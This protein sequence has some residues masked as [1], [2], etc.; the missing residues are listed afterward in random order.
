MRITPGALAFILMLPGA[1]SGWAD[2]PAGEQIYRKLCASCHGPNGEGTQ[3]NPD[4]LT[5]DKSLEKLAAY[6]D[7]KMPK[8]APEKCVGEDAKRVASYIFDAFYS[9]VA[10]ARVR[11][12]R[13]ELSRLTVRQYRI[14]V[15][16]LVASLTEP[17]PA[18]T[19]RG[20][21]A[22]Y[23][24]GGRRFREDRRVL[25]RVEPRPAFDFIATPA[26]EGLAKDE[27]SIRWTGSLLAPATG[28]YEIILET[29]NGARVLVNDLEQ[30]LIDGWVRSGTEKARRGSIFLLGGR[31]YPLRVEFFKAKNDKISSL[32]LKWK[33]PDGAEEP[34][35]EAALSPGRSPEVMVVKTRFP[36]DDRSMGYERGIGISKEWDEAA[37]GAA[38]EIAGR[39]AA[40][41][42]ELAG[43]RRED[44][45][46][47]K[48]VAEFCRRLAVRAFRRPLTE[49]Q[50]R[51]FV[52][53]HF[54]E[55]PD[56]ETAVKR[57]L[58]RILK[59]PRFLY[60]ELGAAEADG[61]SV[62]S[63]IALALW[64]SLPDEKLLDAA[65]AGRLGNPEG[66]SREIERML[67]DPRAREK[68]REFFH[69][70]LQVD[71]LHE[72]SKDARRYPEFTDAVVADLRTS[73]DLFLDEVTWGES[74]DFRQLLLSE[75]VHLNG[76]L[77]RVYGVDIP[78]DAPF[79]RV[80]MGAGRQAGILTHPLLMA[81]FAYESTSSPIHRGVFVARSLLGK[82]LRPPPDA[83]TPADPEL[84]PDL[85]TRDRIAIQTRA[86]S[87]Q[88]CHEMINPLG[89][90]LEHYDAVG[91]YREQEKGRPIDAS[92]S[93]QAMGG[94]EVRFSGARELGEFLA[95]SEETQSAFVEH[96]F[97]YLVKQP[98]LAYGPDNLSALRHFAAKNGYSIRKLVT[99][100]TA[101][102]ALARSRK[103]KGP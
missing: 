63:R 22:E 58:L 4:P 68:L 64:D 10:Q 50:Q 69:Y 87:C 54:D 47:R 34:V 43:V 99:Q 103:E 28:E 80:P 38:L 12:P 11:P 97:H 53:R 48:R 60:P 78:G 56:L 45:G 17:G 8:D 52:H 51:D 65:R 70:W 41:V 77:A 14:S 94:R 86:Q 2:D 91:R 9:P 19:R 100:M 31:S 3:K 27:Y 5:G 55:T 57:V 81:G 6:I 46:A 73:L 90:A 21:K 75:S 24:N 101:T 102:S 13:I 35:P 20:L 95:R 40:R 71:R 25:D 84:Q 39:L 83:V 42:E 74:S 66:V 93:Y 26:P 92:G 61:Y 29:L 15:A 49:E 85:S 72:L 18:E 33:R 67:P 1:A 30:P 59:S 37:T 89:F 44:P 23:F 82:R 16:D 76:R 62:A 32:Q 79:K 96:L 7:K 88:S 36:P 98:V